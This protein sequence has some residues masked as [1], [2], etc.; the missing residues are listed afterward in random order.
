MRVYYDKTREQRVLDFTGRA[1]ALLEQLKINAETVV[2]TK[3]GTIITEDE[4]LTNDDDIKILSVV[5]GG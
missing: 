2:I 5:S 4:E 1:E 3:N